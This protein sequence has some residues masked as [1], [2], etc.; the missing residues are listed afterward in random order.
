MHQNNH[1][2]TD[3]IYTSG[4]DLIRQFIGSGDAYYLGSLIAEAR[5][6]R[7]ATM[8]YELTQTSLIDL[9]ETPEGYG[10]EPFAIDQARDRIIWRRKT[11][12]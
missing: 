8:Y 1:N 10:W 11:K 5:D 7:D 2:M 6:D 9:E 3:A 4:L 12:K